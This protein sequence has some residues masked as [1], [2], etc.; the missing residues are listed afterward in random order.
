MV[1]PYID[2][3]RQLS[4]RLREVIDEVLNQ[5]QYVGGEAVHQFEEA[6]ARKLGVKYCIGTGSGTD[7][8][9][10]ILKALNLPPGSEVITPAWSCMPS[11][12]TITLAGYRPVFCD[13]DNTYMVVWP[14]EVEKKIT[15]RTRAVVAVHLY[16]QAAPVEALRDLCAAQNIYLIEDCAQAHLSYEKDKPA[17]T[18]GVAAAFSFYPTKNLGALGDGGCVVTEDETLALHIRKL[19]NHGSLPPRQYDYE[20][21]GLNSRLDTLQAAVLNFRLCMLEERN[22]RRRKIALR[23]REVLSGIPELELPE[24]RPGTHHSWHIYCLRTTQRD[25]LRAYLKDRG[26]ETLV[27]YPVALPLTPAFERYGH[28]PADF[29]VAASLPGKVLSLPVFP[30]LTDDEIER[31]AQAVSDFFQ[32]EL[33][34]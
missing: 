3:Q 23:Y 25:A 31:V 16:G 21:E 34:G 18:F 14:E 13:V 4:P 30:E 20:M 29:P 24:E 32:G 33:F 15:P 12:E 1:I 19:A 27:H 8:L 17:G 9:F 5:G 22:A 11:A 6:F 10:L 28:T 2:L 26:I 7:A